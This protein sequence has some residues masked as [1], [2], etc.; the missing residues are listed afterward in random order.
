MY[1]IISNRF[2]PLKQK[3]HQGTKDICEPDNGPKKES[4]DHQIEANRLKTFENWDNEAVTPEMLAKA[5]F[6]SLNNSNDLVKC[7]FCNAEVCRWEPGDNPLEEHRKWSPNCPFLKQKQQ[8]MNLPPFLKDLPPGQDVCGIHERFPNSVP[9]NETFKLLKK[10]IRSYE[11]FKSRLETFADWPKALKLKPKQLAEAGFYYKGVGDQTVCFHCGGG[12]KD[13]EDNDDPWEQH[14]LWFPK[15]GYL[16]TT[17]G[18]GF[19]DEVRNKLKTEQNP[20]PNSS[21]ASTKEASAESKSEGGGAAQ[22][23]LSKMCKICFINEIEVVFIPCGHLL[24]CIECSLSLK[25]CPVCRQRFDGA[26]RV[27]PS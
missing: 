23:D 18:E 21:S 6:Y 27:F 26:M 2:E 20:L 17:K 19:V 16:I 12:L 3:P 10:M 24:A 22:D 14:A 1:E 4:P 5:G 11:D 15:C 13:W 7:A 25:T 9:E 8:Q